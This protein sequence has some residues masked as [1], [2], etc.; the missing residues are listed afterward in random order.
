VYATNLLPSGRGLVGLMDGM[1]L[2]V[3]LVAMAAS[4]A[5]IVPADIALGQE[6]NPDMV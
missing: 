1:R 4:I 5:V 6:A 2:G 3:V